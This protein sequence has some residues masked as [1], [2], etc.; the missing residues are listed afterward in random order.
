MDIVSLKELANDLAEDEAIFII[1]DCYDKAI[2]GLSHDGRIVYSYDKLVDVTK[3]SGDDITFED[4]RAWVD[5]N[6]I[7]SLQSLGDKSPIVLFELDE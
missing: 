3:D 1:P 6:V 5:V 2:V 4:A 7:Q